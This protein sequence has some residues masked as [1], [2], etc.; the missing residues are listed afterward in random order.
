[1][2]FLKFDPMRHFDDIASK[3]ETALNQACDELMEKGFVKTEDIKKRI[4][5]R[6]L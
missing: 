3:F 6:K 2:T 4:P 1:M 5:L